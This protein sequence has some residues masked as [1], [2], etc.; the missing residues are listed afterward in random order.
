[1]SNEAPATGWDENKN[2]IGSSISGRVGDGGQMGN[3]L[4]LRGISKANSTKKML[5]GISSAKTKTPLI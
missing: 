4:R 1:M 3:G 5:P 2:Q